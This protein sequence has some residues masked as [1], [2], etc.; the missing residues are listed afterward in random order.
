MPILSTTDLGHAFGADDL[1]EEV[2]VKLDRR[3]RVGLVGPNGAG[4]STLL[5]LLAG[6]LE[7]TEGQLDLVQDI[8]VGV[9]RQEAVLTFAG[10][11]KYDL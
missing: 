9:L 7:P 1:F 11:E 4:K 5:M 2:N 6:R 3:D 8:S 10:Q